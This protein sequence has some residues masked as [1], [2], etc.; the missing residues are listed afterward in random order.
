MK[1]N[2]IDTIAEKIL[3]GGRIG[4]EEAEVLWREAPL[5]LL[6]RLA[7]EMK[8][9]KSYRRTRGHRQNYMRIKITGIA[10]A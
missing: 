3:A 6:G 2:T 10:K 5:S 8:R 7:S 1:T 9:R 4:R